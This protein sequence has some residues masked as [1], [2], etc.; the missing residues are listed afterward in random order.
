MCTTAITVQ[1]SVRRRPQK[2]RNLVLPEA[3]HKVPQPLI[4]DFW[5]P[6]CHQMSVFGKPLPLKKCRR[7]SWMSP[8]GTSINDVWRFS[9]IFDLPTYHV[10]RFLP[11]NVRY[12]RGFFEPPYLPKNR[13]SFMDVPQAMGVMTKIMMETSAVGSSSLRWRKKEKE[14]SKSAL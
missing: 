8:K 2:R 12:L 4:H 10:R 14:K 13:R 6:S 7:T 11:Y 3:V 9:A 1:A 5:F